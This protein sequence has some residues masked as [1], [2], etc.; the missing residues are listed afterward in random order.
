MSTPEVELWCHQI[1]VK[2]KSDIR[3]PTLSGVLL[4][5]SRAVR[6]IQFRSGNRKKNDMCRYQKWIKNDVFKIPVRTDYTPKRFRYCAEAEPDVDDRRRPEVDSDNVIMNSC[7]SP[8][9]P[10]ICYWSGLLPEEIAVCCM[11]NLAVQASI[12]DSFIKL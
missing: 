9:L 4:A 5:V 7:S 1:R 8:K 3:Y 12:R 11:S 2:P 6:T 10:I